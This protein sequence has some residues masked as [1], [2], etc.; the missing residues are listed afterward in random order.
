MVHGEVADEWVEV[1]PHQHI[2]V[3]QALV[4]LV[5]RKRK[6]VFHQDREI[7]VV[8]E[9]LGTRPEALDAR[10]AGQQ[11]PASRTAK[12]CAAS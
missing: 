2:P 5:A 1:A 3:A 4:Q 6:I 8:G 11:A 12:A 7:G 10:D 9:G